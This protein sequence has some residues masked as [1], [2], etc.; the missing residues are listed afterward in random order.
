VGEYG[1]TIGVVCHSLDITEVLNTKQQIAA[2]N[3]ALEKKD[4]FL[5]NMQHDIKTPISNIVGLTEI[6]CSS[7]QKPKKIQ[8]YINCMHKTSKSLM[9]LVADMLEFS[10]LETEKVPQQEWM[11]DL[12]AM[13]QNVEE[14]NSI[15]VAN[16]DL[17]ILVEHD[18][19]LAQHIIA[20]KYR[21]D[22]ILI[23]LVANALK[24][25]D[26]G[27]IKITTKIIKIISE[28]KAL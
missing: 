5:L 8:E 12:K 26:Q 3:I 28:S 2:A 13:L 24:F 17:K 18:E 19:N 9:A 25:T 14:L 1:Q 23:N 4:H 20:D 27:T 22:R 6:L 15:A 21:L 10:K 16:K 7:E 11:F